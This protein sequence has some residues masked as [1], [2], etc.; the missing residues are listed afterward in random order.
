MEGI[1]SLL[2]RSIIGTF[3][4]VSVKHLN[5]YLEELAWRYSNRHSDLFRLT[6]E[7]L[8]QDGNY[9]RYEDLVA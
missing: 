6:L 4:H 7:E 9:M 3:H 2:K 5:L 1:W 8:L